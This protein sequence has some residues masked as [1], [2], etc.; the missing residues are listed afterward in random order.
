[1]FEVNVKNVMEEKKEKDEVE[2]EEEDQPRFL[3]LNSDNID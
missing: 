2:K 3:V 1:M